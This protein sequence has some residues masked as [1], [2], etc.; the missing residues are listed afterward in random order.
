MIYY[1]FIITLTV[2][3]FGLTLYVCVCVVY[4]CVCMCVFVRLCMYVDTLLYGDFFFSVRMCMRMCDCAC[5]CSCAYVGLCIRVRV[6]VYLQ[7]TFLCMYLCF[8]LSCVYTRACV[9][10]C[11]FACTCPYAECTNARICKYVYM[12]MHRT[13]L[14]CP[15]AWGLCCGGG[16]G[17]GLPSTSL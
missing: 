5:M 14:M 17:G 8:C 7:R 15:H 16:G 3:W 6:H 11:S 1:D 4:F 9:S 10:M 13:S 12:C 2:L